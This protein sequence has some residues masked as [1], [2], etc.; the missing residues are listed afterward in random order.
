MPRPTP[1]A[2]SNLRR[3][4]FAALE[5]TWPILLTLNLVISM[6][7]FLTGQ[8]IAIPF[9]SL[10]VSLLLSISTMGMMKGMLEHLRG[11]PLQYDCIASM[12]PHWTKV[13]CYE[14]WLIL[15]IFLWML[16][17]LLTVLVGYFMLMVA[18]VGG[19][20]GTGIAALVFMGGGIVLMLALLTRTV[21]NYMMAGCQLVDNPDMGGLVAL[22]KSK[23]MMRG[24][25]WRFVKMNLP[26]FLLQIAIMTVF[27][28]LTNHL[29][30]KWYV[31]LLTSLLS[32]AMS[33][34]IA[35]FAPVFY[36]DLRGET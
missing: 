9:I 29:G 1:T 17:G 13:L 21:L 33:V 23:E 7:S 6:I 11:T 4:A 27:G 24:H 2:T 5:K 10:I 30:D 28:I 32:T 12:F 20:K 22:A 18:G 14:L 35:Y 15:F 36:R 31:S 34:L 19:D 25:R 26:Y 3:M 16:P 8:I